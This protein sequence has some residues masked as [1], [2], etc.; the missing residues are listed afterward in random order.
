MKKLVLSVNSVR[1]FD[2]YIP[3]KIKWLTLPYPYFLTHSFYQQFGL[4]IFC[5]QNK[6]NRWT[7][8]NFKRTCAVNIFRVF[9]FSFRV[10]WILT[11]SFF[12]PE[13]TPL[14]LLQHRRRAV[15]HF[16]PQKYFSSQFYF[17]RFQS[18]LHFPPW[19]HKKLHGWEK[20]ISLCTIW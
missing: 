11:G 14:R 19:S 13:K 20:R 6:K 1:L 7:K 3:D 18:L 17:C 2:N 5:W 8:L 4:L 10:K 12:L 15:L 16:V 9:S